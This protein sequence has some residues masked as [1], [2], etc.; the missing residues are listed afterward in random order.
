MVLIRSD[1]LVENVCTLKLVQRMRRVAEEMLNIVSG[2]RGF[3]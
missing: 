1:G 2:G 3:S